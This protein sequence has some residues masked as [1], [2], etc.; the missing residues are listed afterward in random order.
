MTWHACPQCS[1]DAPRSRATRSRKF[2]RTYRILP[3]RVPRRQTVK[4][5][6]RREV[7]P[8]GISWCAP[9]VFSGSPVH[10][11]LYSSSSSCVR[12][13]C[14]PVAAFANVSYNFITQEPELA[15]TYK[16]SRSEA[17]NVFSESERGARR[18]EEE[19][20]SGK[21]SMKFGRVTSLTHPPDLAGSHSWLAAPLSCALQGNYHST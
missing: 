2:W 9:V 16:L 3:R 20:E 12:A 21:I 19:S 10:L 11:H 15:S 4:C 14:T 8:V 17:A 13:V 6:S 5:T 7:G 18:G 1:H